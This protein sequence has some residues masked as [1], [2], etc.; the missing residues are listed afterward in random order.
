MAKTF[1]TEDADVRASESVCPLEACFV[2]ERKG[3]E[4]ED[5]NYN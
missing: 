2:L 1:Q 5:K 3:G 4:N